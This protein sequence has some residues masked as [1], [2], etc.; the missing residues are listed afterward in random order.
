[1]K[2][3]ELPNELVALVLSEDEFDA[4]KIMTAEG[5]RSFSVNPAAVEELLA[6]KADAARDLFRNLQRRNSL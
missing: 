5:A 3:I 4:L 1:M 6:D 2:L